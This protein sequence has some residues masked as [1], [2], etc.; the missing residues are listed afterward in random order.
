MVLQLAKI[1]FLQ[2]TKGKKMNELDYI[3]ILNL[4]AP[5]HIAE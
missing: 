2:E 1:L 5:K 4:C 3:K